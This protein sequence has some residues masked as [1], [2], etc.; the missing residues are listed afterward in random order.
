MTTTHSGRQ[1]EKSA[2]CRKRVIEAVIECLVDR[3]YTRT[4]TAAIACRT[5]LSRGAILHHFPS[6]MVLMREAVTYLY[7][8][9]LEAI[10]KFLAEP[11]PGD[12]QLW[13]WV[14][15]FWN[16]VK[17]PWYV[18]ILELGAAARTDRQLAA[19]L[20]PAQQAFEDAFRRLTS[21]VCTERHADA[22]LFCAALDIC[23]YAMEGMGAH[24]LA[25]EEGVREHCLL[26]YLKN[27]LWDVPADA[28][29]RASH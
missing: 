12:A 5:G 28:A 7:A 24:L 15:D 19:T 18:A 17:H 3:G 10:G 23:R 11:S 14:V 1:A 2:S 4:T 26:G 27:R 6:R 9:R 29:A 13:L 25:H 8:K 22:E 16:Y 20:F 21:D